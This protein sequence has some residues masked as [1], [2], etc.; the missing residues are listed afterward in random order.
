MSPTETKIR[1]YSGS[2]TSDLQL[3]QLSR[4][5]S[6][7][8]YS[9]ADI[10]SA[11][12]PW[13]Q[14]A[15]LSRYPDL[16]ELQNQ[17]SK[18]YEIPAERIVPTAG[19]DQ[20]IESVFR[21]AW[22]KQDKSDKPIAIHRPSF[23]MFDVYT[24]NIGL[25]TES[26]E[27]FENEFPVN[28]FVAMFDRCM[29]GVIVSPNN[30]TGNLISND[31]IQQIVLSA[32]NAGIPLLV[33]LAYIEFAQS[34]PTPWLASQPNVLMIRT[35]SKAWG[36]AG[37]RVG[38]V[39]TPNAQISQE[40]EAIRGPFPISR[41][42]IDLAVAKLANGKTDTSAVTK[43][44]DQLD[45]QLA[46]SG[47]T[48]I[49]SQANFLL[50]RFPSG[51]VEELRQLGV[52]VRKFSGKLDDWLR[53]T[54]PTD[55]FELRALTEALSNVLQ[56]KLEVAM[57]IEKNTP[58]T[59]SPAGDRIAQVTRT[60]RETDIS[61]SVN[62]DGTGRANINT[63]LGFLDHMLTSLALHSRIDMELQCA[64]DTHIDDHHTVEDCALAL[65]SAISDA[66][67][68]RTGIE[69]FASAY[70]PLDEAL[71]RCVI[72]LSG[73]PA[74]EIHLGFEREMIGQVATENLTHFFQSLAS[75]LKC[76]L[77]IDLIRGQND[78]HRAEAAFKSLALALRQAVQQNDSGVRSTKGTLV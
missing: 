39:I 7:I 18:L 11:S 78:H 41:A 26:I 5:E 51:T 20:G 32:Q 38:C 73:R 59:T 31:D 47:I 63:G 22:L 4:N 40:L 17:L 21:W 24:Q 74:P 28:Q 76:A 42:S 3:V 48:T 8:E 71:V 58:Q 68:D 19:G 16:T 36:L 43:I 50:A 54:I 37:L 2:T 52:A 66:L 12:T 29:L 64:G 67:G 13:I 57:P 65:G 49:R 46:D 72:D 44:R 34:D 6:S 75:N 1:N 62:L 33:D 27:W 56:Q 30:P 53:I 9:A 55:P 14:N 35:L 77:H 25:K 23:E 10:A 69:R 61:V 70:A 15:T 45:M 60:T